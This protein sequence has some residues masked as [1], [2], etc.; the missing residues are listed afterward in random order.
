MNRC[1]GHR[2]NGMYEKSNILHLGDPYIKFNQ[3]ESSILS[4]VDREPGFQEWFHNN[5]IQ[6]VIG[7]TAHW[8]AFLFANDVAEDCPWINKA[9]LEKKMIQGNIVSYLKDKLEQSVYIWLNIETINIP[10]YDSAIKYHDILI[11]GYDDARQVLYCSDF[12]SDGHYQRSTITYNQMEN[13]FKNMKNHPDTLGIVLIWKKQNTKYLNSYTNSVGIIYRGIQNYLEGTYPFSIYKY[14][15]R[16]DLQDHKYGIE[17]YRVLVDYCKLLIE[18]KDDYLDYRMFD[19]LYQHKK[20]MNK[21]IQFIMAKGYLTESSFLEQTE[22]MEKQAVIIRNTF[23]KYIMKPEQGMMIRIIEK[24]DVLRKNEECCYE[25]MLGT[26][27]Q[28]MKGQNK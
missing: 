3:I 8:G 20:V 18:G 12:F 16:A 10:L 11:Y 1:I 24:L 4:I 6:L 9:R 21:R 22:S 15:E 14:M 19:L 28:T 2:Q 17:I 26:M 7:K 13:G 5:F 27:A 23:L 25:K